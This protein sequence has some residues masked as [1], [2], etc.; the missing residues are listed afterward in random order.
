MI[1]KI[2]IEKLRQK[3]A[4]ELGMSLLL[5]NELCWLKANL[6]SDFILLLK[7]DIFSVG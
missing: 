3:A 1:G 2:T 4:T 7:N 5:S 6:F